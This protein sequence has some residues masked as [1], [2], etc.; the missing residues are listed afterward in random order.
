MLNVFLTGSVS[1]VI[2]FFAIP[3]I[4]RIA[5]EKK[6]FDV[7]NDRKLHKNP[8]ASLGGVGIFSG[9]F[10]AGL[11]SISLINNQDFQYYFAAA[12]VVFILGLKDDIIALSAS[13]KFIGQLIAAGL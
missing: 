2:T 12:L 3:V 13:K 5:E 9:F 11:L 10:L 4:I 1:F 6:L 8:T 7:P